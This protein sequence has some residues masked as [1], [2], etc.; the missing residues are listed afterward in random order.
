M[1]P[2]RDDG[3][4]AAV[5]FSQ[6][7]PRPSRRAAGL[8]AACVRA[9]AWAW[10]ASACSSPSPPRP[11][12]PAPAPKPSEP[13]EVPGAPA[14]PGA[15]PAPAPPPE[16]D[17]CAVSRYTPPGRDTVRIVASQE[18]VRR[19][20]YETLVR[21]DCAGKLRPGLA[22]TW[23]P[24]DRG[25]VWVL[26]LRPGAQYWDGAP[27][28]P[29]TIAESWAPDSAAGPAVQAAGILAVAAGGERDLRV[30]LAIA[31]DSLPPALAD[32]ALAV[33]RRA[34]GRAPVGTGRYRPAAAGGSPATLLPTDS[35]AR[36]IVRVL[37]ARDLRDALDAGADLVVTD[38][39]AT[40]TYAQAR[41]D[42]SSVPLPWD[43]T[44]LLVV[45][46]RPGVR[47]D[48]TSTALLRETLAR[49]AVRVDARAAEPPFPWGSCAGPLPA[50]LPGAQPAGARIGY[51]AGDRTARDLAARI[52][53]IGAAP[54]R[55]IV[56][57]DGPALRES[58]RAARET[59]YVV[60]VPKLPL[61]PCAEP[62]PWPADVTIVPLVETRPHAIVRRGAPPLTADWDGTLR[63]VPEVP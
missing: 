50:R 33:V 37:G 31:R 10:L 60:P 13:P 29:E 24:E 11:S 53:A 62:I 27:V 54:A 19:Q 61:I 4:G 30:T 1:N 39:P 45:P 46:N 8:A 49:D 2:A 56:G 48:T 28:T 59:A 17:Q 40:L 35:S 51:P 47:L 20:L 44:Y 32:P 12:E 25:R 3:K 36:R 42:L 41:P 18:F 23:H 7:M 34:E 52:V 15:A 14:Q 21:F 57:L 9:L 22:V 55:S 63:L 6:S 43:R 16:P 26:T 38:D 58:I 5:R